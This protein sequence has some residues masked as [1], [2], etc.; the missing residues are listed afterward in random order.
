MK[1]PFLLL[2]IWVSPVVLLVL[3]MRRMVGL[4]PFVL[5]P[6]GAKALFDFSADARSLKRAGIRKA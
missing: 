1:W 4:K 3:L 6:R 5:Q 2:A